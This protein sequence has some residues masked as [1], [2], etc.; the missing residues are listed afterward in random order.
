MS[1]DSLLSWDLLSY[2]KIPC[3]GIKIRVRAKQDNAE[4][5]MAAT[6]EEQRERGFTDVDERADPFLVLL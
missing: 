5:S 1:I 6:K 3:L 4:G 2:D